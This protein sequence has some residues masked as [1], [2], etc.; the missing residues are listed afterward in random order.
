MNYLLPRQSDTVLIGALREILKDPVFNGLNLR[1]RLAVPSAGESWVPDS[2]NWSGAEIPRLGAMLETET[3]VTSWIEVR[4]PH[5]RKPISIARTANQLYDTLT[6]NAEWAVHS[7]ETKKDQAFKAHGAI[8]GSSRK[9]LK[10]SA[11][12]ADHLASP[13]KA[14]ST[15]RDAQATILGSLESTAETILRRTGEQLVE[16]DRSREA[17]YGAMEQELRTK[18]EKKMAELDAA[19]EERAGKLQAREE[20]QQRRESAFQ[21]KESLYVGRE[22]QEKQIQELQTELKSW[23]LT[24]GT[25]EKRKAVQFAYIVGLIIT[26][27]LSGAAVVHNYLV[28]SNAEDLQKMAMWQ[29]AA[30]LLKALFP[31]AG[32]TMLLVA[33]IRWSTSWA[34]QHAEEEFLNRSRLFDIGRAGWLLE[35]VRDSKD[36]DW[37]LPP[38]LLSHLSRNLFAGAASNEGTSEPTTVAE[39]MLKG[40]TSLRLKTPNGEFEASKKS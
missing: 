34:R 7:E 19:H 8:V 5:G 14:W 11:L 32:F 27:I 24:Q 15:Y 17:R 28:V 36:T 10:A 1:I 31:L 13:D 9:N 20:E 21:T 40:L 39:G 33:Y 23:S 18:W 37:A 25:N 30:L 35:A 22:K 38:E 12:E 6:V 2:D 29:W 16:A 4:D 26:A 3:I